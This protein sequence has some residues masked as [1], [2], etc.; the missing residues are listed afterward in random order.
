MKS[1]LQVGALAGAGAVLAFAR[2][3][4]FRPEIHPVVIEYEDIVRRQPAIAETV[5][6]IG[7]VADEQKLREMLHVLNEAVKLASKRGKAN[8]WHVARLN[9][10]VLRQTKAMCSMSSAV[11]VDD[12]RFQ[13]MMIVID[14]VVPQ[15][16]TLL[17]NMLHNHILDQ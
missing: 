1:F 13:S 17:D 10:E 11:D 6:K 15:I 16:E 8:Q 3:V 4:L 2:H 7:F 5:S 14:E 12:E 9:G